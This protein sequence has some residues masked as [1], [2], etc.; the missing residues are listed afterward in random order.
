MYEYDTHTTEHILTMLMHY[1]TIVYLPHAHTHTHTPSQ[2]TQ[3]VVGE[4]EEEDLGVDRSK[5]GREVGG[6]HNPWEADLQGRR[7]Q[8]QTSVCATL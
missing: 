6:S 3:S 5:E 4:E 7:N 8:F 2:L 1:N